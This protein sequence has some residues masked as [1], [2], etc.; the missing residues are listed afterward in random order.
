MGFTSP[1]S[2]SPTLLLQLRVPFAFNASFSFVNSVLSAVAKL[3][4]FIF[5]L[6]ERL[7]CCPSP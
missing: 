3:A 1:N 5:L 6:K 2:P 4:L 7:A